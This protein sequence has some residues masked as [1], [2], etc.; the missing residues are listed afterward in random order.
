[1]RRVKESGINSSGLPPSSYTVVSHLLTKHTSK[2]G[3]EHQIV[4]TKID[5]VQ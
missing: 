1:M 3:H 4:S 5:D 2:H